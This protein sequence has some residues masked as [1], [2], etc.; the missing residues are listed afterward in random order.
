M[1]SVSL[2]Y[3]KDS[4]QFC[5]VASI[6]N[7]N[8]LYCEYGDTECTSLE[9][10]DTLDLVLF[11]GVFLADT[12][13]LDG[14]GRLN[15]LDLAVLPDLLG[16]TLA[17]NPEAFPVFDLDGDGVI[18]DFEIDYY[19]GA[20]EALIAVGLDNGVF[21]DANGDC[22][23]DCDDFDLL[24]D[25]SDLSIEICEPG[26]VMALDYD[27]DLVID[28][29]DIAQALAILQPGDLDGDRDVDATDI[30]TFLAWFNAQDPRADLD[31]D[32][33]FSLADTT[34]FIGWVNNACVLN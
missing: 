5:Y 1:T 22:D 24:P 13:D 26:Y 12:Y 29:S 9:S 19:E 28:S 20:F 4:G 15:C 32:G 23:L 33:L 25:D 16:A 17:T 7:T 3:D 6:Q 21:G 2:V 8:D 34:I 31:G 30:Q 18:E 27:L 14:D 11:Q 10:T